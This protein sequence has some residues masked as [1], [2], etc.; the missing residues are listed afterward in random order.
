MKIEVGDKIYN[1]NLS[2]FGT[3]VSI[4]G[5]QQGNEAWRDVTIKDDISKKE[6]SLME[7]EISPRYDGT[8]QTAISTASAYEKWRA[9]ELQRS[10]AAYR[11]RVAEGKA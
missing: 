2:R 9:D 11:A 10:Y 7:C 6:Y 3:V 1:G 8:R 5:P 4:S